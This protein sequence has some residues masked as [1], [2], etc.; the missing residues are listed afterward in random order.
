MAPTKNALVIGLSYEND[1]KRKQLKG[2]YDAVRIAAF[3]Y[4]KE[5]YKIALLT[6]KTKSEMIAGF[7][8][9]ISM[10]EKDTIDNRLTFH[11][12]DGK[13]ATIKEY[14][15]K[16]GKNGKSGEDFEN[17]FFFFAGHGN[18]YSDN[19]LNKEEEE[20]DEA[21][22]KDEHIT[23]TDDSEIPYDELLTDDVMFNLMVK[24]LHENITLTAVF[25]CCASGSI[26]D[27]EYCEQNG[28]IV[29]TEDLLFRQKLK[30]GKGKRDKKGKV[31][32][33]KA[34]ANVVCLSACLDEQDA[35]E[36]D[37]YGGEL[38]TALQ[39]ILTRISEP[40]Y[41]NLM[42]WIREHMNNVDNKQET[43]LSVSKKD[44]RLSEKFPL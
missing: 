15:R 19:P 23:T 30:R 17:L 16:F 40:T 38:T 6:E 13:A 29:P 43:T 36:D 33:R 35:E 26:L 41:Q 42:K 24:P 18:Q 32:S 21:D 22:G 37:Y 14:M 12:I 7:K 9:Y 27:L 11:S 28:E 1:S 3:L 44:F 39:D 5:D 4:K 31:G 8:H 34:K 25:D 10:N 20:I 2:H